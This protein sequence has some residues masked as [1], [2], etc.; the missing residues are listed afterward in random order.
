MTLQTDAQEILERLKIRS[1]SHLA[2]PDLI[3]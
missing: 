3:A 2:I 1:R